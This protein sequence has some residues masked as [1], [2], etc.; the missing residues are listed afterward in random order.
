MIDQTVPPAPDTTPPPTLLTAWL[1]HSHDL[2]A[3]T[4]LAGSVRWCNEAFARATGLTTGALL[5]D[6]TPSTCASTAARAAIVAAL[7]AGTAEAFRLDLRAMSGTAVQLSAR[8]TTLGDERLW[9]AQD[10]T[11][12]HALAERAAQLT[13]LLDMAQEFGRLGFWEREIPSGRGR[14]DR[15][16]FAFWGMTPTADP[17]DFLEA[18]KRIHPDDRLYQRYLDSTR[19][20]GRY[21]ARYRVVHPDSTMRRVQSQW[22]IKN[23]PDGTPARAIGVMF[24]D[25]DI[26]DLARTLDSASAQL[27]LAAELADIVIWRHDLQTDRLHY[28]E[29][30]FKVLAVPFRADGLPLAE[31]RSYTHPDDLAKLA[32][33]AE[34]SLRI[35]GP[36][37]VQTR[38]RWPDGSWRDILVRRVV[39]RDAA[40]QPRAFLGVSLDITAQVER[41]RRAEAL[42]RHLEAAATAARIGIW[43]TRFGS[44]QTEWNDQMYALFDTVDPQRPPTLDAWL[45]SSVHPDDMDRVKR[46]TRRYLREATGDLELEFRSRRRDGTTRWMVLR[47][48]IDR[49]DPGAP[50]VLGIAM[51]VTEVKNAELAR[52][53]ALLAE[54]ESQAKSHFLSR[55]SHELRTPLN[56]VLGF[57]QLLQ[58]EAQQAAPG[59]ER[60]ERL[61]HIRAAGEQLL[62]LVDDALDLSGLQSGT[63]KL[64]LQTL[65]ISTVVAQALPLVADL[66]AR[67]RVTLHCGALDGSVRADLTRL[68]QVLL[69]LLT[70]AIKY[71][72]PG[73]QVI[74]DTS[75]DGAVVRLRVCDTGRGMRAEQLVHLYEPF[76]RFGVETEGIAGSG[77]G[78][79]IVKALVE[80]MAGRVDVTSVVDRGTTFEVSLPLAQQLAQPVALSIDAPPAAPPP[81]PAAA[82]RARSGQ[83][84]YI[85]DNAVNVMLVEELVKMSGL[86]FAAAGCGAS[87]VARARE[88]SPQLILIDLQLP[89]FDGFEVLRRLR[90]DPATA[91]I[92]CI[93]LSANAM[94]DD[95]ALGLA[96]GFDDYW[97]K[98]IKFKPFLEALDRR[99]PPSVVDG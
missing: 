13:E 49:G 53:Q 16:V 27:R 5:T 43:T 1:Q 93:A 81:V 66:A 94:P 95:I 41:T 52:Q 6:L 58:I 68:L 46:A 32:A 33:S 2:V 69:N 9:V 8:V 56:A 60:A 87:G 20:A 25:T 10:I 70:N 18:A 75:I 17:P 23:G 14:W 98:P 29:H 55:M 89:D 83:L 36:V 28:N 40:G 39:E 88:L 65:S 12:H 99:F 91:H 84:L 38:H 92:P 74:V 78:L 85:E 57:T 7:A 50:R 59:G 97:T 72:R 63:L 42:S 51:D 3:L 77:I 47:A 73:G 31:A 19:R 35:A 76:N 44:V 15:H 71:N 30:G 67:H 34:Q 80:G 37:D 45:A 48:D 24:D 21:T 61:A 54:R 96:G 82:V 64:D 22:E 11:G 4:D 86:R 90:A 79:T 62:T 26:Y